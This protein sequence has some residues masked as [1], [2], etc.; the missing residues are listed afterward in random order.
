M[1]LTTLMLA[2]AKDVPKARL[3]RPSGKPRVSGRFYDMAAHV[4][5]WSR[6]R[7]SKA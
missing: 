1:G 6:C 2:G 4:Q 7:L 5:L 3:E